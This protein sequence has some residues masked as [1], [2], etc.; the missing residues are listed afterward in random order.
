MSEDK[1]KARFWSVSNE[2]AEFTKHWIRQFIL[3]NKLGVAPQMSP[4]DMKKLR[5][6]WSGRNNDDIQEREYR[7]LWQEAEKEIQDER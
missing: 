5:G 2:D 6:L 4:E 1:D 7:M 3:S